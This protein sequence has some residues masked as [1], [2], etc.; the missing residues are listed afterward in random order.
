MEAGFYSWISDHPF[1]RY[2][3]KKSFDG[4]KP[5]R[6]KNVLSGLPDG[7]SLS[8]RFSLSSFFRP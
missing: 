7:G 5:A 3:N 8:V 6:I 4:L 1:A 2:P